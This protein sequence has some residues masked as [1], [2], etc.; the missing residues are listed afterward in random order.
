MAGDSIDYLLD[1]AAYNISESNDQEI[2]KLTESNESVKISEP[3]VYFIEVNW[4]ILPSYPN[5]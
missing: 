5:H 3:F 2:I 1:V 4:C